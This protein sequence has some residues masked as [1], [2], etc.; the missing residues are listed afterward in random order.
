MKSGNFSGDYYQFWKHPT[1]TEIFL[2]VSTRIE[3]CHS[4]LEVLKLLNDGK[5]LNDYCLKP[6]EQFIASVKGRLST[7]NVGIAGHSFGG[8]TAVKATVFK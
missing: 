7:K 3:E 2:Q 8:V 5:T 1:I 4:A 6:S